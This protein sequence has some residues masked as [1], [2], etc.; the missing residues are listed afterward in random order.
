MGCFGMVCHGMWHEMPTSSPIACVP[1]EYK[2]KH[3]GK[4]EQ[5]QHRTSLDQLCVQHKCA[6]NGKINGNF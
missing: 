5:Q 6:V 1:A 2:A 3:S 4:W